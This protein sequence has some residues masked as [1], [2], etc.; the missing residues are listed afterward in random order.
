MPGCRAG[1][2][3]GHCPPTPAADHAARRVHGSGRARGAVPLAHRGGQA[4]YECRQHVSD[5]GESRPPA[6]VR[7]ALGLPSDGLALLPSQ[8][9]SIDDE[10]V[11][12]VTSYYPLD[13]AR[14]TA[15]MDRRKIRGGTPVLLAALGH[16][17]RLSVDRVSARIPTQEQYQALNLP[18]SLPL[19]RTLRVVVVYFR[20]GSGAGQL[21]VN[22]T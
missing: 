1:R 14:G 11:E 19:L 17:P 21:L 16:Q 12:L 5:V 9:L 3:G 8:I 6:D 7:T 15:L 10:P 2:S 4:R 18:G 13:V 20:D 22:Q